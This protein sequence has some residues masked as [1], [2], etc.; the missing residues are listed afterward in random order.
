MLRIVFGLGVAGAVAAQSS[1]D[2]TNEWRVTVF[3]HYPIRGNLSGFGYMGWVK[4][5]D[6]NY[7]LW[8]G[9]FPGFIYNFKPW[10]QGWGGLLLIYTNNYT[11]VTGKQDTLELRPFIGPKLFVPNKRKLNIYNFTR[12]EF[13]ETYSHATHD[14]TNAE[15]LRLRFAVEAPLTSLEK[16]WK[17]KTFYGI[18]YV[19]PMYRFDKDE[20][21]PIRAQLGVGYVANPRIRVELLYYANWS[22]TGPSNDFAFTENIIR[23]NVK[24]GLKHSLLSH[25]WNPGAQN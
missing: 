5:P 21:D 11:D 13:R 25:V 9:G 17:V 22:R 15:R 23:L 7:S 20:F 6:A 1:N 4:N 10:F 18:A 19:E 2:I 8:Y 3:P 12:V 16:A 14:W 24:V